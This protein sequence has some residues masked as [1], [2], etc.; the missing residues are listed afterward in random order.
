M[1]LGEF[2]GLELL[3]D[4]LLV[5][6]DRGSFTFKFFLRDGLIEVIILLIAEIAA[7]DTVRTTDAIK[8]EIAIIGFFAICPKS[9]LSI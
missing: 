3:L 1:R 9:V 8:T 6:K 4:F 5:V 2:E 7:S